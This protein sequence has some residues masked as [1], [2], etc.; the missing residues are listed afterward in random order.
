[1]DRTWLGS[2][3]GGCAGMIDELPFDAGVYLFALE[4]GHGRP[5]TWGPSAAFASR[6]GGTFT[7][8]LPNAAYLGDW[9]AI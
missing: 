9:P 4:L 5:V 6:K 7:W 1:M 8:V 2:I 3:F